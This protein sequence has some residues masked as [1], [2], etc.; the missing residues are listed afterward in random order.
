MDF[1]F[2][3]IFDV[4]LLIMADRAYACLPGGYLADLNKEAQRDHF[5]CPLRTS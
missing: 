2:A 1:G 4:A 3:I 5:V